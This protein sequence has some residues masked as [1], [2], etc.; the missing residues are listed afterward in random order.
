MADK[1]FARDGA[2]FAEIPELFDGK[3]WHGKGTPTKEFTLE[4]VRKA[5]F[6][7]EL[8]PAGVMTGKGF[9]KTGEFYAVAG[10]DGL[11]VSGA[12]GDR[13]WTPQNE[14]IFSLFERAIAGSGYK[15]VS[16]L[17]IDNRSQFCVDAKGENMKAGKREIAPFVGAYRA[18]GG[19]SRLMFPGH[20]QVVQCANTSRLMVC[21]AGKRDDVVAF[22]NTEGLARRMDE[23]QRAVENIHG[24]NAQ[25][26]A[27]MKE[28][29]EIPL[30]VND[31][32]LAFAG[33]LTGGKPLLKKGADDARATSRTVNR[34]TDLVTLFRKGIGN[35]GET[36]GDWF[37]AVT[38]GYTH[39]FAETSKRESADEIQARKEKQYYSSEFGSAGNFKANVV[40]QLFPRQDR[41]T[42][43]SVGYIGE[44]V[45]AGKASVA[46][47]DEKELSETGFWS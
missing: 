9:V 29:D 34:V 1:I 20:T 6:D 17:T 37:N 13:Y 10:D 26:A 19:Q 14:E 21:E 5:L 28:A 12:V 33:L 15:I 35:G 31:A 47:S 4:T 42:T 3:G 27:A 25:F 24:V 8:K 32:R 16:V 46:G 23:V 41:Q 38:E 44:L 45:E 18:F 22:R 36:V 43:V 40:Q 11:P 7:Y 39:G 2:F 30:A